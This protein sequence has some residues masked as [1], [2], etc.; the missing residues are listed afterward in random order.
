MAPS[1]GTT[2]TAPCNGILVPRPMRKS[3]SS[4]SPSIGSKNPCSYRYLGKKH[5]AFLGRKSWI[6]ETPGLR[7]ETNFGSVEVKTA[8]FQ[9]QQEMEAERLSAILRFGVWPVWIQTNSYLVDWVQPTTLVV[10]SPHHGK[11]ITVKQIQT[12]NNTHTLF[13]FVSYLQCFFLIPKLV[14]LNRLVWTLDL[15]HLA[16]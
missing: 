9:A 10:G 11:G 16:L 5:C 8:N 15:Q 2:S 3:G 14:A 13:L 12:T 7:W 4:P 6:L 1:N